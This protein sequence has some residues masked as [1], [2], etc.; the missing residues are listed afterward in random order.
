M[1]KDAEGAPVEQPGREPGSTEQGG[2]WS[3]D[4]RLTCIWQCA[5]KRNEIGFKEWMKM[6]LSYIDNWSLW[7]DFKI[8]FQ[9]AKV[10][11]WGEGR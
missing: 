1:G 2:L 9:T 5:P 7:H 3:E 6:D 10:V 11:I 8:L 4:R